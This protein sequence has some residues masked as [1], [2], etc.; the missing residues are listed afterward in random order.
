MEYIIPES[1]EEIKEKIYDRRAYYI[2]GGT[3]IMVLKKNGMLEDWPWVDISCLDDLKGISCDEEYINIGSLT[4]MSEIADRWQ[5]EKMYS[6]SANLGRRYKLL[7][8]FLKNLK[9]LMNIEKDAVLIDMKYKRLKIMSRSLNGSPFLII[10]DGDILLFDRY[11]VVSNIILDY[12]REETPSSKDK[13]V[14]IEEVFEK[15]KEFISSYY[16]LYLDYQRE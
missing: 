11:L 3:D 4:A 7:K 13:P 8:G 5:V 10:Y 1:I 6:I 16:N 12:G 9:E 14:I 2:A 15:L